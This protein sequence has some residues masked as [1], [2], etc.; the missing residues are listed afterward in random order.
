MKRFFLKMA[1]AALPL[2]LFEIVE[3]L[4]LPIDFFAFRAWEALT[5]SV[6]YSQLFPGPFYPNQKLVKWSAGDLHPHGARTRLI[7]FYTDEYGFRNRSSKKQSYDIVVV[8]DSLIV[9]SHLKQNEIIS[10]A[11]ERKCHC[12]VYNYAGGGA[13]DLKRFVTDPRFLS[14]DKRPKLVIYQARPWDFEKLEGRF[15]VLNDDMPVR[16]PDKPSISKWDIIWDRFHKQMGLHYIQARWHLVSFGNPFLDNSP[17]SPEL[18]YEHS[19]KAVHSY[20]QFFSK[21]G[22]KFMLLILPSQDPR[23]HRIL[24]TLSNEGISVVDFYQES[25]RPDFKFEQVYFEED[26]HWRP[27]WVELAADKVLEQIRVLELKL[28]QF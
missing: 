17:P 23:V 9:G 21:K 22:I 20:Q 3:L 5:P 7:D 25:I 2:I 4:V 6:G 15:P 14:S 13:I 16:E 8:G 1:I 26:T 18:V 24:S 11:L 12:S 19:I 28:A 27:E 10:E